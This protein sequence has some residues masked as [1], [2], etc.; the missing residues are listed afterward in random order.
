ML[1]SRREVAMALDPA[2]AMQRRL[3]RIRATSWGF[4]IEEAGR[5]AFWKWLAVQRGETRKREQ[6]QSAQLGAEEQGLAP[7]HSHN[8]TPL[9][10][11]E[12][13]EAGDSEP[14]GV[15]HSC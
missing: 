4:S 12:F 1:D 11:L 7:G 10:A 14:V 3:S 2:E 13:S 6:L 8:I 9:S 5:L 15:P